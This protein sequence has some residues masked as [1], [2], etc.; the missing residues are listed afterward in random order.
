[1]KRRK[2]LFITGTTTAAAILPGFRMASGK[3]G[4]IQQA[5]PITTGTDRIQNLTSRISGLPPR[6]MSLDY[7][8]IITRSYKETEGLPVILRRANAFFDI[9]DQLPID[10]DQGELIVGNMTPKPRMPYFSP[11]SWHYWPRH[12]PGEPAP[13]DVCKSLYLVLL[14]K[15]F[16]R[17][18]VTPVDF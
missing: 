3:K 6:E 15:P 17:L 8:R 13:G 9:A 4:N 14:H 5:E 12:V 7:A 2:F 1:M 10:L 16:D 11:E 18:Q